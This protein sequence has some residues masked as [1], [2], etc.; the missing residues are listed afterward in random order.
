MR[1]TLPRSQR[2]REIKCRLSRMESRPGL[3]GY[4]ENLA[5]QRI[6]RTFQR[7]LLFL[8]I[9]SYPDPPSPAF[10]AK[11]FVNDVLLQDVGLFRNGRSLIPNHR[12]EKHNILRQRTA[13]KPCRF[14]PEMPGWAKGLASCPIKESISYTPK[15]HRFPLMD[16]GKVG[17]FRLRETSFAKGGNTGIRGAKARQPGEA[18]QVTPM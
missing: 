18:L 7:V 11:L 14:I 4:A 1:S 17:D 10:E 3:A 16:K 5:C 2:A 8:P 9:P 15:R 6:Q 13:L 12:K